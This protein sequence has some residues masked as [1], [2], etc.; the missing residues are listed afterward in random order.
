VTNIEVWHLNGAAANRKE[1]VVVVA[2]KAH[3]QVPIRWH[4]VSLLRKNPVSA[5]FVSFWLL[6]LFVKKK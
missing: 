3:L 5:Q 4:N 2:V 1:L 6:F